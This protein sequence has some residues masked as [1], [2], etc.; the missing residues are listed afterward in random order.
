M[1]AALVEEGY[2]MNKVELDRLRLKYG[3]LLRRR[4][5]TGAPA[6]QDEEDSDD[7]EAEGSSRSVKAFAEFDVDA[8][9][10][11]MAGSYNAAKRGLDEAK[12]GSQRQKRKLKDGVK[13]K[14]PS[15]MTFHDARNHLQLDM[16][17]YEDIRDTFQETCRTQNIWK[18]TL[19][20]AQVWDRLKHGLIAQF[21]ALQNVMWTGGE[22]ELDTVRQLALDVI[23]TNTTKR[24]RDEGKI[25][26]LSQAKNVLG[27]DP[28]T[29]RDVR[30][31]LLKICSELQV[32]NKG[33]LAPEEWQRI[34][35]LW[36]ERSPPVRTVL[37]LP[38][39]HAQF[40]KKHQAVEV[41][42]K[43]TFKV[44]QTD[45]VR[46]G[47]EQPPPPRSGPRSSRRTQAQ[48]LDGSVDT[49]DGPTFDNSP[50]PSLSQPAALSHA[51][52]APP[53]QTRRRTRQSAPTTQGMSSLIP[54]D[55]V[56]SLLQPASS[57]STPAVFTPQR[58]APAPFATEPS[59]TAIYLRA[60]QVSA[61]VPH[62]SMWIATMASHTVREI[63]HAAAKG[64]GGVRCRRV[65]GVVKDGKGGEISLQIEEDEQLAAYLAHMQGGAPTFEVQ[66]DWEGS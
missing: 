42:A 65:H 26:S 34:K 28:Q 13:I 56:A 6:D 17:T 7:E 33:D 31:V 15:E 29:G 41:I 49:D 62:S 53:R 39:S 51:A 1:L 37:D 38:E 32:R 25:M 52:R 66:L 22:S 58:F 50:D 21:P 63:R 19:C 11:P 60:S 46:R 36:A 57:Y 30:D 43:D 9:K 61:F 24:L 45:R 23:C 48:I 14:F 10:Y 47:I 27:M 35:G 4:S 16:A 12:S 64:F 44:L 8:V 59:T 20:G 2:S 3:W 54:D 5:V 18:K 40:V 55:L